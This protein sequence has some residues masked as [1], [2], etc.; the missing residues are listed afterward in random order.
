MSL[1]QMKMLTKKKTSIDQL[2]SHGLQPTEKTDTREN[3]K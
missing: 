1:S 3:E 2:S